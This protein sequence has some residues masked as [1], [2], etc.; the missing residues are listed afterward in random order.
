MDSSDSPVPVGMSTK[1]V[2]I[3]AL[4]LSRH[5]PDD[6]ISRLRLPLWTSTG[7]AEPIAVMLRQTKAGE[8]GASGAGRCRFCWQQ[9]VPLRC[10]GFSPTPAQ[11]NLG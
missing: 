4:F 6:Q 8:I 2:S 5:P 9:D 3:V 7:K 10:Q 11:L 1:A